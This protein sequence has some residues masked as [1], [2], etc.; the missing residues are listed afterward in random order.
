LTA[1]SDLVEEHRVRAPNGAERCG[2]ANAA[3]ALVGDRE[4]REVVELQQ[5][6]VVVPWLQLQRLGQ[7]QQQQCF[8]GA[9][10]AD[11][12]QR[13]AGGEGG[14]QRGFE[15]VVADDAQR[16]EQRAGGWYGSGDHTTTPPRRSA[17]R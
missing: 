2:V 15:R 14:K 4:A 9:V 8:G 17:G 10:V 1:A 12:E 13:F 16:A 3:A 11:E 6:R 7:P 5:R